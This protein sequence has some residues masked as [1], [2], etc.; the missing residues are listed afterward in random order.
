DD[1]EYSVPLAKLP[2]QL[3]FPQRLQERVRFD[4]VQ[5]RLV[6]QGFMTKCSYDELNALTDDAEYHRALEELF[7]L[8]A[9]EMAASSP[10]RRSPGAL[11][12]AAIGVTA[13][14]LLSAWVA[15]RN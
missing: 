15:L 6:F 1:M 5:K 8:T 12:L 7:V 3:R 13:L 2:D 4:A 14:V 9:A 11:A 10:K